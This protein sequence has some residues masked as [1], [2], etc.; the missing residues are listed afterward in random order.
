MCAVIPFID[1]HVTAEDGQ[2]QEGQG[3]LWRVVLLQETGHIQPKVIGAG[4]VVR[5]SIHSAYYLKRDGDSAAV[6]CIK[7]YG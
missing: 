7:N 6:N 1:V 5:V 3:A 4:Q 2:R